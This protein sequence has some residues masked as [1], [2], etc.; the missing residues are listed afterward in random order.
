MTSFATEDRRYHV[1]AC[2]VCR[3]YLKSYNEQQAPRAV[4][5]TVDAL[6]TLPLDAAAIQ[7]GYE[8]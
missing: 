1:T 8:G 2:E 5:P 3:R 7:R 6:R 4:I